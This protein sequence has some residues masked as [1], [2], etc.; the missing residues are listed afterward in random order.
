MSTQELLE[1]AGTELTLPVA[2]GRVREAPG[3][4]GR[5]WRSLR[6][7]VDVHA[8]HGVLTLMEQ[9]VVSGTNF[10]TTVILGRACLQ[11]ELG[12]YAMGFSLVL[13]LM[14]VSRALVWMP[15]TTRSPHLSGRRLVG[16]TGS[17]TVHVA[18]F[19]LLTALG[20]ALAA[21]ATGFSAK[22]AELSGLLGVLAIAAVL[23]LLREYA[24]RIYL[25]RMQVSKALVLNLMLAGLQIGG[26]GFLACGGV[27][28]ARGAYWVIGAA[29][30]LVAG[31]WWLAMRGKLRIRRRQV[32]VDWR[33]NWRSARWLFP[34]AL[35]SVGAAGVYPWI[36][37]AFHGTGSVG[38]LTAAQGVILFANPLLLGVCNFLGPL[39]AHTYAR[40]GARSLSRAIWWSTLG[41]VC[42]MG[43]FCLL[44]SAWG[45]ELVQLIFGPAYAG[46]G[47]VVWAL[48]CAQLAYAAGIPVEFG[49]LALHRA[50]YELKSAV[51]RLA[52]TFTLGLWFVQR[53]GAA[54]VG[55]G[56]LVGCLAAAALQWFAF[57]RFVSHA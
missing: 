24:R 55:Y 38:A 43:L 33:R 32:W 39:A 1:G 30:G 34:A 23:M 18:G 57:R 27:L 16:Y 53:Y 14:G 9:T 54:G 28:S 45:E 49:L 13:M 25:A 48:A 56:I 46:Q 12:L 26:L 42:V 19:C 17:V 51:L 35:I 37:A 10:A 5:L 3:L 36:L 22:S 50:D 52:V 31:G 44:V 11:H 41:L 20:L 2:D 7:A 6:G 4:H 29:C 40:G 21:L 47:K 8:R 15:Y